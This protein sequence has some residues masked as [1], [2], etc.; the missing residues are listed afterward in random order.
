[1]IEVINLTKQFKEVKAVDNLS[2]NINEGEIVGLLGEN[3][4]GKTT[5]LRI[6]S[7][8]IK[9]TSGT[10]KVSGFDINKEP[11]K[12]RNEIGIL[13]GGEVG[14]YDRLTARENIRYFAEL[15]GMTKEAADKSIEDLS[16]RLEMKEYLDRRVGKFSRGMKQKVAIARSIVHEPKV[17][18]LDEPT[19]GL[20]VTSSRLIHDFIK[21]CKKENKAIVFSSH[22][23][24][25]VE[26]LCDRIIIIHKGKMLEQGTIDELKQKY[27]NNDMEEIFMSLVGDKHE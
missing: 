15:N 13:F 3:G 27:N 1:M 20:D 6:I 16:D 14:L 23:M 18:L 10:V 21:H 2:F 9:C 26:K 22:S 12:V 7:T 17:V 4:A 24:Q 19:A 25:E 5:T 8:M 11:S